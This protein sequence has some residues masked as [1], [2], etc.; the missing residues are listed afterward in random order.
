[1]NKQ[2]WFYIPN[3]WINNEEAK[4]RFYGGNVVESDEDK[5]EVVDYTYGKFDNLLLLD[6]LPMN[7]VMTSKFPFEINVYASKIAH[8]TR[9]CAGRN[10]I[11]SQ[12]VADTIHQY[13]KENYK[14]EIDDR[15][16]DYI[17]IYN[18]GLGNSKI[19]VGL[20]KDDEKYAYRS[21]INVHGY[22]LK[23]CDVSDHFGDR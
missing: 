9:Q 20:Y 23:I 18:G 11:M 5:F 19:D 6:L 13:I 15:L 2:H 17:I 4:E 1:M 21:N 14:I 7:N 12:Q 3:I 8:H 16:E 10:L 22:V